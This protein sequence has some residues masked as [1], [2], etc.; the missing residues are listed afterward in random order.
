MVKLNVLTIAIILIISVLLISGIT[1]LTKAKPAP[2]IVNTTNT[3]TNTGGFKCNSDTDCVNMLNKTLKTCTGTICVSRVCRIVPTANCCGNNITE[4]IENGLPGNKCSCPKDYGICNATIKYMD[5]T[6]R[7]TTAKY[8]LR[9]CV[10]N[11]CKIVY[12]DSLQRDAEFFNIWNGQGF[13]I[14]I[15]VRYSNPFYG[16]NNIMQIETKLSDYDPVLIK[17]PIIINEIRLM[18]GT[19]IFAKINPGTVLSYIDQT[20]TKDITVGYYDFIYPEEAKSLTINI[21]YE[22]VPLSRKTERS[23]E[24]TITTFIEMP[25]E[26]KTYTIALTERITF[27]DKSLILE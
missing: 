12:D 14:N 21:D 27:L 19:K 23:G 18:E 24:E 15:Y 6:N 22:Y 8:I 1:L 4:E 3:S 16:D 26:R 10:D 5:A 7:L 25:V 11:E 9:K 2:K 20:V 17:P 13:R